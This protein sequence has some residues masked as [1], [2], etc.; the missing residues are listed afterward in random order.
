MGWRTRGSREVRTV[1]REVG[2]RS[3]VVL[4]F[5]IS[6]VHAIAERFRWAH[7]CVCDLF[8]STVRERTVS[9][10]GL[11]QLGLVRES[12]VMAPHSAERSQKAESRDGGTQRLECGTSADRTW[13]RGRR[14]SPERPAGALKG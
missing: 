6:C 2:K 5:Y 1:C 11:L 3:L 7:L 13:P 14:G 10:F 4:A 8:L 9:I 12:L